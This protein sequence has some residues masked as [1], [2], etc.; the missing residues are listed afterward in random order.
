MIPFEIHLFCFSESKRGVISIDENTKLHWKITS[1]P[2]K[3]YYYL[4]VTEQI[5]DTYTIREDLGLQFD[6][7]DAW[8]RVLNFLPSL[9]KMYCESIKNVLTP[10]D[11]QQHYEQQ[12]QAFIVIEKGMK[13]LQAQMDEYKE[14][15]L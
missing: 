5:K 3:R 1:D 6:P 9:L 13:Y 2:Q 7:P 15:Y 12:R 10:K 11:I 14:K 4:A 8:N